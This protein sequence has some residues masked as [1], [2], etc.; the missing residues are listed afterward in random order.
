MS[1]TPEEIG[2]S[3]RTPTQRVVKKAAEDDVTRNTMPL[4]VAEP[5]R[6]IRR[7]TVTD[8]TSLDDEI[9]SGGTD[10]D[11]PFDVRS[12]ETTPHTVGRS[13]LEGNR[14]EESEQ[15]AITSVSTPC[16]E[17]DG[18]YYCRSGGHTDKASLSSLER[19][20]SGSESNGGKE[21]EKHSPVIDVCSYSNAT[22]FLL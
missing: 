13:Y 21:G 10:T 11:A 15:E 2:S 19:Y 7:M 22:L 17:R 5:E 14:G 12:G 16:E 4:T 8:V 1:Y 3:H 9:N 18:V 6:G 20:S